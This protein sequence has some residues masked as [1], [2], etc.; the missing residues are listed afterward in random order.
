MANKLVVIT[1]ISKGLGRALTEEF[2]T[3]D[4]Y[5]VAGCART[6][7][8]DLEKKLGRRLS[9]ECVDVI[10]D[11][12]VGEWADRVINQ[13][14]PPTFLINNAGVLNQEGSRNPSERVWT[15]P[16]EDFSTVV[17]TNLGGT[18]HTIRHF[19][20]Q[21]IRSGRGLIV[22]FV[23]RWAEDSFEYPAEGASMG[24]YAASKHGVR[25]LTRALQVGLELELIRSDFEGRA[26]FWG[27]RAITFDP[28]TVDTG[29]YRGALLP[30]KPKFQ[31]R[32]QWAEK[33]VH[34]FI[35]QCK[36]YSES[37][38]GGILEKY[39]RPLSNDQE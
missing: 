16:E 36:P 10:S 33:A 2:A 24:A 21:V 5:V 29:M 7:P 15:I 28:S 19:V 1:G 34:F 8:G 13:H 18:L 31:S 30:Q 12:A 27:I 6:S 38:R 35:E 17:A 14:G 23:T 3:R 11:A 25:G 39:K 32:K 4:G 20:P 26:D 22:N 9:F 37:E